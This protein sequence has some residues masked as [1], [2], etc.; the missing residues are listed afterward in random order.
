MKLHSPLEPIISEKSTIIL[1]YCVLICDVLFFSGCFQGFLL[2]LLFISLALMCLGVVL[3]TFMLNG[4][5]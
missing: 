4:V 2:M 3:L 1:N 5:Y